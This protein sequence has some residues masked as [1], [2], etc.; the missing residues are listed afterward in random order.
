[1]LY[2]VITNVQIEKKKRETGLSD[3]EI[4][5][6]VGRAVKQHQDSIDQFEKAGRQELAQKEKAELEILQQYLPEQLKEDEIAEIVRGVIGKMEKLQPNDFGL[7]MG[8]SMAQMKGRADG[9]LVGEIVRQ[10]LKKSL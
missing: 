5:E 7:V 4:L 9:K 3:E 10:E 1:M 2:E 6:V 8:Q